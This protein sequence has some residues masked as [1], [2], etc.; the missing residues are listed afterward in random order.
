MSE[1]FATNILMYHSI[2][3]GRGPLAIAPDTFQRQLDAIA[4]RG[5]RAIALRELIAQWDAGRR[6]EQTIVLTFDDGYRNVADFA[7]PE[8][9]SRGWSCT[10]F[11]ATDLVGSTWNPDGTAARRIMSWQQAREV[12]AKGIEIG[13][14]GVSHSDLTQIPENAAAREIEMSRT[15]LEQR[16]G[17]PVMSFAAP[18]GRIT[19]ALRARVGQVYQ[20]AVGTHMASVEWHHDRL[21]LPRI[22]MWYFRNISR[23]QAYLDGSR[24]Y[25]SLRQAL[26]RA[27]GAA[28]R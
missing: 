20:C 25:F 14:H 10:V 15:I 5:L 16:L 9:R 24:V 18:F 28:R 8:I 13:A 26:R 17:V 22:D 27:R 3:P 6:D 11:L 7:V 21:H 2:G 19:N 1:R 4:R 12:S 23:W